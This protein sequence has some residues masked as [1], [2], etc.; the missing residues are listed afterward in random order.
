MAI[1]GNVMQHPLQTT[2]AG[3]QWWIVWPLHCLTLALFA[4]LSWVGRPLKN[5]VAKSG[6]ISFQFAGEFETARNVLE[7][8][9]DR[10]SRTAAFSLGLDY[11]FLCCYST[12]IA[13]GASG[14]QA[15]CHHGSP[16]SESAELRSPGASGWPRSS[17]APKTSRFSCNFSTGP[18]RHGRRLPG[19]ARS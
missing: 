11:L 12:S 14:Q 15:F 17:T 16:G 2:L 13:S 10:A 3:N 18:M 7:S 19:G 5:D 9:D 1:K 8:W 6:M 4:I